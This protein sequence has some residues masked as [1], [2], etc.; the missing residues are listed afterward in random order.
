MQAKIFAII[1]TALFMGSAD[2][3]MYRK[4]C[5][6]FGDTANRDVNVGCVTSAWNGPQCPAGERECIQAL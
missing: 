4:R 2:A 1:A 3:W 5:C 6:C